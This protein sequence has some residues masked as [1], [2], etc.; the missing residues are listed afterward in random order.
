[1]AKLTL[2]NVSFSGRITTGETPP[3]VEPPSYLYAYSSPIT[4]S[5]SRTT[6]GPN[7]SAPI[8]GQ[9]AAEIYGYFNSTS[10]TGAYDAMVAAT[11]IKIPSAAGYIYFTIP[12]T[13]TWRIKAQGGSGGPTNKPSVVGSAVQ[14]DF[15]LNSGDVLWIT[16]GGAGAS[17]NTNL[18]SDLAGAAGGGFTVVAKSSS[19]SS[20]F[21][22]GDMTALLV[23]AGGRGQPE[24]RWGVYVAASSSANGTGGTGFN[25]NWKN[26]S[27]N[28]TGAGF[29]GQTTYGGFGG[30]SGT[31]DGQGGAGGYDG[32]FYT[33][34]PAPN[35]YVNS[36]A[37]NIVREDTGTL[38]TTWTHG[39]V[40]LTRL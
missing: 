38:V 11:Y 5:S 34:S 25:T 13:G 14:G 2:N 12:D 3:F 40:Q 33:S 10:Q 30:G 23:A 39:A 15:T 6:S 4:V 17:G 9:S 31:D 28:G 22:S 27:I 1:M 35:S 19:G 7:D 18:F 24:G 16:I 32:L 21:S 37:S 36:I 8:S 20:T 29:G 26:Q